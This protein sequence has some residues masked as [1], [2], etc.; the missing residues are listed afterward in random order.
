MESRAT[1]GGG[2]DRES[3][4]QVSRVS[5]RGYIGGSERERQRPVPNA[6]KTPITA[7]GSGI[8]AEHNAGLDGIA[9]R[10]TDWLTD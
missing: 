10:R 3:Q 9:R 6:Q 4:H 2:V 8:G 5:S 1:C 7:G